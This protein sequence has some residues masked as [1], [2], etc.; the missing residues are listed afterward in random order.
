MPSDDY[1][2]TVRGGLKL[3]GSSSAKPS[4]IKKK[5]KKSSA[6][7]S[8]AAAALQK[9][10]AADDDDATQKKKSGEG[11][12]DDAEGL[13]E[14]QLRELEQRGGDGKTASERAHEEMRRKR[15]CSSYFLINLGNLN[16]KWRWLT[17]YCYSCRIGL[18]RRV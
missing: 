18:R 5:K 17:I 16:S 15:V 3:K 10:L 11:D 7:E 9:T 4:G 6:G 12:D 1:S 2:S 14:E 13:S 8:K